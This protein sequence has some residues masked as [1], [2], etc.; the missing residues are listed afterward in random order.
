MDCNNW[1][2]CYHHLHFTAFLFVWLLREARILPQAKYHRSEET[3]CSLY[4][5]WS[6]HTAQ[7]DCYGIE[8]AATRYVS[9]LD[10]RNSG[11][12]ICISYNNSPW[13]GSSP[14]LEI[15]WEQ[16]CKTKNKKKIGVVSSMYSNTGKTIKPMRTRFQVQDFIE[17]FS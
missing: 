2:S 6:T 1:C 8:V 14:L 16:I 5:P 12:G 9:M 15:A 3:I 17:I 4:K 13:A 11:T 7:H 10:K